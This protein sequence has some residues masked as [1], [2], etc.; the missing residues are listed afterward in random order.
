MPP[1]G[2]EAQPGPLMVECGQMATG[3]QHREWLEIHLLETRFP[4]KNSPRHSKTTILYSYSVILLKLRILV[5]NLD[6][7][8]WLC[9]L[10]WHDCTFL[11]PCP[12]IGNVRHVSPCFI[13]QPETPALETEVVNAKPQDVA[14]RAVS[15]KHARSRSD[16]E[17]PLHFKKTRGIVQTLLHGSHKALDPMI[18][19]Y[20]S[21]M[22]H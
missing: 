13:F 18:P 2:Q 22:E 16:S 15:R 17:V 3:P 12:S 9:V 21:E 6:E 14:P 11:D 1:T 20:C 19:Q 8:G 5:W 7:L 10:L 4:V